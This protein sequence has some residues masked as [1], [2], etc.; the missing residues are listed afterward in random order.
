MKYNKTISRAENDT[1]M[2]KDP[3]SWPHWPT[4]P[5]VNKKESTSAVAAEVEDSF[6]ANGK[7]KGK[8]YLFRSANIFQPRKTWGEP[9]LISVEDIIKE[10]WEVD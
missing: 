6:F 3:D 2:L 1:S 9:V 7:G 4:I 5:L 10:G 8:L